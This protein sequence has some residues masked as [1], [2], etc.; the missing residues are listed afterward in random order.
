LPISGA[1][2]LAAAIGVEDERL[3]R[4]KGS[5]REKE[6]GSE[7]SIDTHFD[8]G[9]SLA[10]RPDRCASSIRGP[11]IMCLAAGTGAGR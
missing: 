8:W 4:E 9:H 6:K 10:R 7:P 3:K 1:G 2:E 11:S 5:G